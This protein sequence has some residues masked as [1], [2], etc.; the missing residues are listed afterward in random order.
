MK[1]IVLLTL[2]IF[3][4]L[5]TS[6][7]T[8]QNNN[9]N[10]E[11]LINYSG[12]KDRVENIDY[13]IKEYKD[14][15]INNQY[16]NNFS[17]N[18]DKELVIYEVKESLINNLPQYEINELINWYESDL[19]KKVKYL[20]D[21]NISAELALRI[22][23]DIEPLKDKER[24]FK[25][26]EITDS[27]KDF[28]YDYKIFAYLVKVSKSEIQNMDLIKKKMRNQNIAFLMY[29]YK[30]LSLEELDEYIKFLDQKCA[31]DFINLYNTTLVTS[32]I[33][34]FKISRYK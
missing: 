11:K 2:F 26:V 1:K 5:L 9:T 31:I 6:F 3:T 22:V 14:V 32:L 30:A 29:K 10:I 8:F 7:Y 34:T 15:N 25:I 19:G 4:I 27:L 16:V 33:D 21:I 20:N 18:Y 24:L 13:K 28:E 17:L 12:I 23:S